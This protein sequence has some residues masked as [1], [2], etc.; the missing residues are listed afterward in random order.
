ME[1]Q[2]IK[3]TNTINLISHLLEVRFSK[4]MADVWNIGL[5]QEGI[6][7]DFVD[8]EIQQEQQLRK[9]NHVEI[10]TV[11]YTNY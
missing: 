10:I 3:D 4:Q 1:V 6:D 2:A 11:F 5:T 7:N 9:N 8:L